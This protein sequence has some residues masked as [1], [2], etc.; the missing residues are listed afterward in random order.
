MRT[1]DFF[2]NDVQMTSTRFQGT[3][4]G[5]GKDGL[6]FRVRIEC[7]G[8]EWSGLYSVGAGI[9]VADAQKDPRA[10]G[11]SADDVR[12]LLRAPRLTVDGAE[13]RERIFD[14]WAPS[15]ESVL[16]CLL[17]DSSGFDPLGSFR[18]WVDEFGADVWKHPADALEAWK[19]CREAT[20]FVRR[21][22][23]ARYDEA[24]EHAQDQ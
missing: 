10:F 9:P 6:H 21:A 12:H 8:L 17:M 4:R 23:G 16:E 20:R 5:W 19:A 3:R 1:L 13:I 11:V 22:T 18:E 24:M 15:V 7:E 2:P 14:R